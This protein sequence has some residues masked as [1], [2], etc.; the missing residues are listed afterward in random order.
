MNEITL[1]N[2]TF[3]IF[4][5]DQEIKK[6]LDDIASKINTSEIK[7]PLFIAVLNGSFLFAADLM[8]KITIPNSEISF[9]KLASYEGTEST[10]KVN[11]L[12]GLNQDV[13]GRNLIIIEDIVDTGNTLEK[14]VELFNEEGV[15]SLKIAT[16]LYKE[17]AYTKNIVIDFIGKN[18]PNKF[19]VGYGLDYD[20]IG[21]NL[22]NIYKLKN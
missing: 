1:H 13:K 22:P 6:I 15:Q 9:I 19:V 11:E 10:G 20:E 17:E 18:I 21:R 3:E 8:R 16:L 14:I 2:K 4:I 12:I 5:S 7:N